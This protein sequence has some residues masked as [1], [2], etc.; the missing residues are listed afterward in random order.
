VTG[1]LG[2]IGV[3]ASPSPWTSAP[4]SKSFLDGRW[5]T[6]D[7]RH[8]QRRIG[9][10]LMATGRDAT[11]VAIT[12]SFGSAPLKCILRSVGRNAGRYDDL[13][14]HVIQRS[15][16]YEP[17]THSRSL[18]QQ[19]ASHENESIAGFSAVLGERP[20]TRDSMLAR[21]CPQA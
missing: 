15:R 4:G 1:Y 9:R 17:M 12:T 21:T 6:C 7:A 18:S 8:N 20:L 11:D 10:V 2:D 16:R 13:I 5:W 3:G 14:A 19:R